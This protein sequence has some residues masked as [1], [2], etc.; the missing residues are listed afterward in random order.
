MSNKR[1]ACDHNHW[2]ILPGGIVRCTTCQEE[3]SADDL[4][5]SSAPIHIEAQT[6]RNRDEIHPLTFRMKDLPFSGGDPT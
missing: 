3:I 1:A 4:F 2:A 6:N 5:D